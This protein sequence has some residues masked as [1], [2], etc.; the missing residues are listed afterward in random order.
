MAN[1]KD[2]YCDG[3]GDSEGKHCCWLDGVECP[4]LV[5]DPA[6]TDPSQGRRYSCGLLLDRKTWAKVY[7]DQRYID[8]VKP[9]W[10]AKGVP[11][12]GDWPGDYTI[13]RN[14]TIAKVRT[15]CSGCCYTRDLK[16]VI[17]PG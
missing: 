13:V 9:V 3:F 1:Q 12:C 8:T 7:Q 14:D 11:D 5:T 16:G 17:T 4:F 15:V 10:L 6:I 2:S